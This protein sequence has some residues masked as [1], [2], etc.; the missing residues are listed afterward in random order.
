MKPSSKRLSARKSPRQQRS[1]DTV[2]C[3]LLATARILVQSGMAGF[4][5][6]AV[7]KE[8]G[9]SIG[10]LYQ[11]FPNKQSLLAALVEQK[12]EQDL[13]YFS[14]R[15]KGY[16]GWKAE[17]FYYELLLAGIELHRKDG[18]LMK[19]IFSELGNAGQAPAAAEMNMRLHALIESF[20]TAGKGGAAKEPSRLLAYL[21]FQLVLSIWHSQVEEKWHGFSAEAVAKAGTAMIMGSL[22]EAPAAQ[23]R[24][25]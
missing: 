19:V 22:A 1:R 14:S 3:I 15:L 5:T 9:L 16:E 20:V 24:R 23:P 6:N 4:N 18:A 8:A 17:A 21:H 7:A 25:R 10:S 13:A 12:L 11:Y 2:Q